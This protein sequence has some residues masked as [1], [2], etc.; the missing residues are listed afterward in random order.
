MKVTEK[1]IRVYR[2]DRLLAGLQARLNQAQRFLDEQNR[3]LD[4]LAAKKQA[5]DKQVL[6]ARAAAGEHE[7]EMKR[8]D[9]RMATLREQMDAAKTNK[10]YKAFLTEINTFK[11]E[12]DREEQAALEHMA[13]VDELKAQGGEIEKQ[14][15]E[16][17]KVRGVAQHERDQR[18]AEIKT[19]MDELTAERATLAADVPA[20]AMAVYT[21]LV[22]RMD[23]GA[24][25]S[26][27]VEDFK[28]HEYNCGNCMMSLPMEVV[29]S[30]LSHGNLT[31]CSSCRCILYLEAEIVER[32]QP[33]GSKR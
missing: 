26:V 19:R 1:L 30:L 29:S 32:M 31:R 14:R 2:V 23:E 20:E 21:D 10:E 27:Q 3:L 12:R 7:G 13:K 18:A 16:R 5:T 24:M 22:K 8:L 33:A 6:L 25:A 17:E 11:A 28:R 9:A 4:G 15:A